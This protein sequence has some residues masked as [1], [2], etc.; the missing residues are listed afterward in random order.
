MA[1][2]G[3]PVIAFLLI[4]CDFFPLGGMQVE[5]SNGCTLVSNSQFSWNILTW[6]CVRNTD[7]AC[8]RDTPIYIAKTA[9]HLALSVF[10]F[11]F[12]SPWQP[13]VESYDGTRLEKK[14]KYC[15][16]VCVCTCSCVPTYVYICVGGLVWCSLYSNAKF[17]TP[18]FCHSKTSRSSCIPAFFV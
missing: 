4:I 5:L 16:Y 12:P 7:W 3:N 15:V 6:L 13:W 8:G 10:F 18:R 11:F 2:M 1:A 17:W 14:K 9:T